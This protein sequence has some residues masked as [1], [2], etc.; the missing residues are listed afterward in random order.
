M[1][2]AL[3][4]V[5]VIQW[6]FPTEGMSVVG[7]CPDEEQARSALFNLMPRLNSSDQAWAE[8]WSPSPRSKC[9]RKLVLK[10]GAKDI[11]EVKPCD[12]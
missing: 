7:V 2:A 4:N 5:W 8:L 11:Q 1:E 10:D 6:G 12:P 3:N 9:L